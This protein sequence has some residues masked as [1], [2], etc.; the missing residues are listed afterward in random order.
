MGG[1]ALPGRHIL[2]LRHADDNRV[3]GQAARGARVAP[4]AAAALLLCVLDSGVGGGGHVFQLGAASAR[5]EVP[6]TGRMS[7][8]DCGQAATASKAQT[9]CIVVVVKQKG[10]TLFMSETNEW[11]NFQGGVKSGCH[12]AC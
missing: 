2:L 8:L 3:R 5:G 10:V 4:G 9:R 11:V 6:E 7:W 1:L 12:F